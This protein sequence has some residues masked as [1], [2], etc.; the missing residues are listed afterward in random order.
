MFKVSIIPRGKALGATQQL[1][2]VERYTL[3][4][5]YLNDRLA[6][7]LA[8]RVAERIFLTDISSGADDDIRKATALARSMVTRWG[9][10]DDIGPMDLRESDEHPFLGREIAQPRLHSE[11]SAEEIDAAIKTALLN[12]EKKAESII[13]EHRLPIEQLVEKLKE[14]ETLYQQQIA[15]CLSI[16]ITKVTQVNDPKFK[17]L[18]KDK[19][20]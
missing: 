12:A 8:G 10:S 5:T 4:K 20:V 6:V 18:K 17:K 14:K 16:D 1:P 13:L 7:M 15:E 11:S 9:M 19:I 3:S 2:G